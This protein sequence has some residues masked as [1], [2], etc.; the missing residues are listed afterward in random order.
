MK[1][2]VYLEVDYD[3]NGETALQHKASLDYAIQH[4]A[5]EGLFGGDHTTVKVWQHRVWGPDEEIPL[6]AIG[7]PFD[8]TA[9]YGPFMDDEAAQEYGEMEG[10][11]TDW[12]GVWLKEPIDI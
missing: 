11:S 8:G 5:N 9:L 1:M 10:K 6:C 12:C 3:D 4:L 7:N 2:R